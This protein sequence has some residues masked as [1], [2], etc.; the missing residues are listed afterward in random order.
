M[1]RRATWKQLRSNQLVNVI[2]RVFTSLGFKLTQRKLAQAVPIAGAV[3]NGGLNAQIVH[4]TFTRAQQAY[5]LRFLTEKYDLDP[6]RWAPD[7]VDA[8]F[9]EVPLVDE[10]VD[11]EL[12]RESRDDDGPQT[13]DRRSRSS[14]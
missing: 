13:H 14:H 11:A 5:R 3:I 2:Q 9:T 12:T 1:M 7:V 10:L 8:D 6:T 4:K